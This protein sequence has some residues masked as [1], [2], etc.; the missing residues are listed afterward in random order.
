LIFLFKWI[1]DTEKRETL[2]D[3]DPQLFFANQ[4][5]NNACATQ[6]ILSVLMNKQSELDIGPELQN[7]A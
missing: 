4:V 3:Y 5:I 2:T 7:L 1:K 6:A